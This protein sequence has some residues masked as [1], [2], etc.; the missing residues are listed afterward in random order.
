[1]TEDPGGALLDRTTELAHHGAAELVSV[2]LD[3]LLFTVAQPGVFF[4]VQFG[5]VAD[6]GAGPFVQVIG[7]HPVR[8]GDLDGPGG[9][10]AAHDGGRRGA[11]L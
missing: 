8:I 3:I 5:W 11:V 7:R 2:L 4:P 10:T 1:M 6:P 9:G